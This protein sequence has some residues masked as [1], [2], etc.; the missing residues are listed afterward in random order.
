M[1]KQFTY[2]SVKPVLVFLFQWICSFC[3]KSWLFNP[4]F[5]LS[6]AVVCL[7]LNYAAKASLLGSEA[8]EENSQKK[9]VVGWYWVYAS[10]EASLLLQFSQG[11]DSTFYH[12]GGQMCGR[13]S[14]SWY[15]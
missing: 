13:E 2:I 3:R 14:Q 4:A 1:L 11:R 10:F 12:L 7:S 6:F 8:Q 9:S 5:N 15:E